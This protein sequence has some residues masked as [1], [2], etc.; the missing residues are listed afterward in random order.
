MNQVVTITSQGQLTIP[1]SIRKHFGIVG[2]IKA[3]LRLDGNSIVVEP[4]NDFW[5]LA[6]SL[7]ATKHLTDI[8]LKQ[9]RKAFAKN[10]SRQ[11]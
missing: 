4:K 7:R 2:S 11:V 6:G 1:R 8:Q 9:A 10:W 5:S 3:H